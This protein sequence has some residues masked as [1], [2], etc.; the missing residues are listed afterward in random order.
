MTSNRDHHLHSGESENG[1]IDLFQITDRSKDPLCMDLEEAPG[2]KQ[3]INDV[4][5]N[6]NDTL[7]TGVDSLSNNNSGLITDEMEASDDISES[8]C[9]TS[10]A[11]NK[12]SEA[13]NRIN[14]SQN[15]FNQD[16]QLDSN[17]E[18]DS[19]E[20]QN[21]EVQDSI[22]EEEDD[23][24]DDD[25]QDM[26]SVS[27]SGV[28]EKYKNNSSKNVALDD[29]QL[30]S[31]KSENVAIVM[32]EKKENSPLSLEKDKDKSTSDINQVIKLALDSDDE[33]KLKRNSNSEL[34]PK[35]GKP[36]CEDKLESNINKSE[37]KEK[38]SKECNNLNHIVEDE[39]NL[40]SVKK[41][42]ETSKKKAEID[43]GD[44]EDEVIIEARDDREG[45]RSLICDSNGIIVAE[46]VYRCMICANVAD[47]IAE[48]QKH[49]QVKHIINDIATASEKKQ[50]QPLIQNN[51]NNLFDLEDAS[52]SL[53]S[54]PSTLKY[55]LPSGLS[56]SIQPQVIPPSQYYSSSLVNHMPLERAKGKTNRKENGKLA[57]NVAS[58]MSSSLVSPAISNYGA[59]SSRGGYVTCAVC[60][61]TKFY[62]S[63]QRRYGQFTCMGCAKFFGRFLLKPRKYYCPNLGKHFSFRLFVLLFY[64][65]VDFFIKYL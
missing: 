61:I 35:I 26:E 19:H 59:G 65:F 21:Q 13:L 33:S 31:I 20:N 57:I 15:K 7:M 60:N 39:K 58:K 2:D 12:L 28:D 14:E 27:I 53:P 17:F 34:I 36:D 64:T 25:Q 29:K 4:I 6:E 1:L 10:E 44:D 42:A 63:V 52:S 37:S 43:S 40:K 48:A 5:M 24:D 56:Q 18:N 50:N 22:Q 46:M 3:A 54:Q 41:E 9:E 51:E 16:E 62:A 30:T 49:Y 23:D 55:S 38:N 11:L 32:E 45:C 47:S 8:I